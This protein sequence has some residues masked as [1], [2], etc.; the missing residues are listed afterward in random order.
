MHTQAGKL[1]QLHVEL[2][3]Q[4]LEVVQVAPRPQLLKET[5]TGHMT[6][7]RTLTQIA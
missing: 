5:L 4:D 3:V 6:M 7:Q 1:C 2:K